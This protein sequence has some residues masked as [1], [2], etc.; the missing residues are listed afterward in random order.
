MLQ[1]FLQNDEATSSMTFD[2]IGQLLTHVDNGIY[3]TVDIVR[4][5]DEGITVISKSNDICNGSFEY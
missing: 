1:L 4:D 3:V 5:G 2:D